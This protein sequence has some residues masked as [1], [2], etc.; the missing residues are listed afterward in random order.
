M[1]TGSRDTTT[2]APQ[3]L[4]LLNDP[5]V[6]RQ[7]LALAERL[8]QRARTGRRRR[9]DRAYRLTLGPA[10]DDGGDRAGAALSG[11]LRSSCRRRRN[12]PRQPPTPSAVAAASLTTSHDDRPTSDKPKTAGAGQSRR[13]RP[14][15]A[16][17][18]RRSHR[19]PASP[20]AAAWASFCQALLGSAEFRY[21]K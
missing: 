6:R 16:S 3:A 21:L 2:V 19:G 5:F 17:R 20:Q 11:R 7:S 10:G 14:H 13:H 8:L 4:Y 9:V 12:S 18:R 1:V 15:R